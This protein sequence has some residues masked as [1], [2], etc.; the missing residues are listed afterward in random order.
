MT[1]TGQQIAP[2]VKTRVVPLEPEQAFELFTARA[3]EWWPV[4]TH[5]IAKTDVVGLR[6]ESFVGGRFVE[7][8]ADG[9]EH[10]WGEVLTWDPPHAFSMTWHP[11]LQP[12]ATSRLEV[13]FTATTGGT[14]V[15]LVHDGWEAFGAE[16]SER[17]DAYETGWDY[18]LVPFEAA[19]VGTAD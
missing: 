16:G 6:F 11:T 7:L 10:L 3:G 14:E 8:T 12:V 13:R 18:V 15:S 2:V 1:M 19:A 5:S 4:A 17:R 9:Q